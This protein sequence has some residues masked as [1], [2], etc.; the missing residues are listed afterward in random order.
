MTTAPKTEILKSVVTI[1]KKE[2]SLL[3]NQINQQTNQIPEIP[4]DI[5]TY[6]ENLIEDAGMQLTPELHEAMVN[7]LLARLEKRL[8]AD[9]VE[10]MKPENVEEF[11]QLIQSGSNPQAMQQYINEH[12]PNAK[13]IFVQS[14]V[15]FRTY[16]LGGSIQANSV[17]QDTEAKQPN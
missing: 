11:T 12:V 6:L 9:A 3:D 14:L 17:S 5:K 16:F 1:Y 8:I 4:T 2:V 10:N 15:D 13:E 7:D